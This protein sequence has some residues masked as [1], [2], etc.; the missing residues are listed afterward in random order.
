LITKGGKFPLSRTANQ[1]GASVGCPLVQMRENV[2]SEEAGGWLNRIGRM[3]LEAK[4]KST[5]FGGSHEHYQ[6]DFSKT[7]GYFE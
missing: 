4:S 5:R 1:E 7:G 6:Q 3:T 2:K